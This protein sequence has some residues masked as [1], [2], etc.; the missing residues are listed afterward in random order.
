MELKI[1]PYKETMDAYIIINTDNLSN[2]IEENLTTLES[3]S[4]SE[5]ANHV[6]EEILDQIKSLKIMLNNLEIWIET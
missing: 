6:K 2:A 5:Y 1:V 3:I 4:Q